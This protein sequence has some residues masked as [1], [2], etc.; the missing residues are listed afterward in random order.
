MHTSQGYQRCP[1]INQPCFQVEALSARTIRL[2]SV[3]DNLSRWAN[4]G[5]H[6]EYAY[7]TERSATA[8]DVA[9]SDIRSCRTQVQ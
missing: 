7:C 9:P 3:L 2:L 4:W 5:A 8:S 1:A 6:A